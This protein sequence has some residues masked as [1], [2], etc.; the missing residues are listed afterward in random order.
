[1]PAFAELL[2]L[3][4]ELAVFLCLAAGYFIGSLKFRQFSLGT[5]VGTLLMGFVIGQ[6]N[7]PVPHLLQTVFF[8]LFMF[9]MGYHV[10]PQFFTGLRRGGFKA[11]VLTLIFAFVGLITTVT[12]A[13]FFQFDPGLAAGLMSGALTQSSIIGTATDALQRLPLEAE[14]RQQLIAHVPVASAVT[15]LFGTAGVALFLSQV[16]PRLLRV[17]LRQECDQFERQLEGTVGKKPGRVAPAFA[18]IDIQ[19]FQLMEPE[20]IGQTVKKLEADLGGRTFVQRVRTGRRVERPAPQYVLQKGDVLVLSGHR[21]RLLQAQPRLGPAVVDEEAMNFPVETV[22]VIITQRDL[23]GKTLG[24]FQKSDQPSLTRIYLRS[25]SRQGHLLPRLPGT[26]LERGDVAEIVGRQ[27]DVEHA[28][29]LI[30]FADRPTEKTDLVYMSL[31]IVAGVLLG[32]LTLTVAQIPISLGTAGGVLIAG[33]AFGWFHSLHPQ[34]GRIPDAAVWLMQTL[35]LNTF[36]ACI[37]LT[38]GPHAVAAMKSNGL[39]LLLAGVILSLTPPLVSLL[40]GRHLLKLNAGLLIGTVAGAGMTTASLQAIV[41]KAESSVPTL[42]FT[43]P[44]ALNSVLLTAWGPVVVALV[45]R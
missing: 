30:G 18:S 11:V 35:G 39:Q 25:L 21:D 15:Y 33:L 28:V 42:A 8:A 22:R 23:V 13:R 16:A 12:L 19:A 41:D 37:G 44:Y 7:V 17:D 45:N 38:A 3:H 1:M 24:H 40:I 27:E 9:A 4:P 20:F 2:R 10:G 34:Y 6:A 32:I 26:K 14:Q 31:A 43:V 5:V 36:V 29:Q